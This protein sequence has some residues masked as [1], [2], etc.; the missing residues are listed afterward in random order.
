M[1]TTTR[2]RLA[3]RDLHV[4]DFDLKHT[5]ECGQIFRQVYVH[6]WYYVHACDRLFKIRQAAPDTVQYAGNVDDDFLNRFFRLDED[7]SGI[8]AAMGKDRHM[9]AAIEHAKGLRLIRQDSWE[10]LVSY[11]CSQ[12]SHIRKIRK[13]V[14]GLSEA[15]GEPVYLENRASYAFP[16]PGAMDDLGKIRAARTGY[17]AQYLYAANRSVDRKALQRI[18]AMPYAA[19]KEA[20]MEL[21][22]VGHKVADCVLLFGLG[23]LNAFPVDVWVKRA[24]QTCYFDG[25]ERSCAQVREFGQAHFGQYAGY[26]QQYLFYYWR[27]HHLR[28]SGA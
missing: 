11:I 17:R 16:A 1:G 24:V 7:L 19:A 4:E 14:E 10:C 21:E 22:G 26:A 20:L 15:F 28:E 5:L 18:S 2:T 13:N 8:V 6:G 9:A 25:L 23:F 27:T 12:A 3:T